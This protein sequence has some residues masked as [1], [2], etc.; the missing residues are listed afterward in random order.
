MFGI[1]YIFHVKASLMYSLHINKQK[2]I[3]KSS[4]T[5]VSSHL[6][7]ITYALEQLSSA[8]KMFLFLDPQEQWRPTVVQTVSKFC[9]TGIQNLS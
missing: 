1:H 6:L 2:C 8:I 4:I 5:S 7:S 9:T 3:V